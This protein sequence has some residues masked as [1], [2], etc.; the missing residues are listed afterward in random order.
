[1]PTAVVI[2]EPGDDTR[3]RAFCRAITSRLPTAQEVLAGSVV[4]PNLIF[5]RWLVDTQD[6]PPSRAMD[7][8]Y[9][10]RTYDYDRAARLIQSILLSEGHFSARGPYLVMTIPDSDGLH[11]AG[12]DGSNVPDYAFGRFVDSWSRALRET[13]IQAI[14]TAERRYNRQPGLARSIFNL[15]YAILRT[16][17][18]ATIGV[19]QGTIQNL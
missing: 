11:I 15:V 2:L 3:N 4:A 5:T 13:Q 8:D 6:V 18:D 12:Y 14:R 9:L 7:C 10:V 16:A 19:L 17:S 1:M